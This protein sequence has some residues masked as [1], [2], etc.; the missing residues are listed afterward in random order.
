MLH[1]LVP[2]SQS[3]HAPRTPLLLSSAPWGLASAQLL[4]PFAWLSHPGSLTPAPPCCLERQLKIY[5]LQTGVISPNEKQTGPRGG[6]ESSVSPTAVWCDGLVSGLSA[7]LLL[8][9]RSWIARKMHQERD[10]PS[11]LPTNPTHGVFTVSYLLSFICASPLSYKWSVLICPRLIRCLQCQP[12]MS[13][14]DVS[15][16]CFTPNHL[17]GVPGSCFWLGSAMTGLCILSFK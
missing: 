12:C 2:P 8:T 7:W 3:L 14:S 11:L 5:N 15:L 6:G 13:E 9:P 10:V 16:C 4:C 17:R 1:L